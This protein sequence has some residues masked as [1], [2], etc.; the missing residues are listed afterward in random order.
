MNFHEQT[1]FD[2]HTLSR[3]LLPKKYLLSSLSPREWEESM[4]K[5][6]ESELNECGGFTM[7]FGQLT[8]QDGRVCN[9]EVFSNRQEPSRILE[10]P[11][12]VSISN[13]PLGD[14]QWIKTSKACELFDTLLQ[15]SKVDLMQ[16]LWDLLETDDLPKPTQRE[17]LRK[18]IFIPH[19]QVQ[20]R[21][22]GTRTET[23]ILVERD[24]HTQ[25]LEKNVDTG[26]IRARELS[27]SLRTSD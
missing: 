14:D 20:D 3:G 21:N 18:S 16:K 4:R 24:G 7:V 5:E 25:Y 8:L 17:D 11:E 13:G 2:S 27:V 10:T 26:E 12:T 23:V 19:M 9:L 22:Y 6:H 15:T 1:E